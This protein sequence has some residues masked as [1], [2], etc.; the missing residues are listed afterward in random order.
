[1]LM[2]LAFFNFSAPE[3][4][5]IMIVALL[6]FGNRLPEVARNLGKGINEFKRGMANA[7]EEFS[8]ELQKEPVTAKGATAATATPAAG[9]PADAQSAASTAAANANPSS[10]TTPAADANAANPS[11]APVIVA[12]APDTVSK[13]VAVAPLMGD[14]SKN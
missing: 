4:I 5:V 3:L 7:S 8:K 1:M 12:T 10:A 14:A 2:T 11:Q 9:A 13:P 6:I